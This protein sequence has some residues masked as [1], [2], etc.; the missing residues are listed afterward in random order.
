MSRNS[1]D[2]RDRGRGTSLA[3]LLRLKAIPPLLET[4]E[5][6]TIRVLSSE[7]RQLEERVLRLEETVKEYEE[8]IR[9]MKDSHAVRMKEMEAD[10][11][12]KSG[13][14]EG[15]FQK[16]L[17]AQ[18]TNFHKRIEE[19][20]HEGVSALKS[21][22]DLDAVGYLTAVMVL[23]SG[24]REEQDLEIKTRINLAVALWRFGYMERA[25]QQL[26]EVLTVDPE[27][28]TARRNLERLES[29]RK[30]PRVTKDQA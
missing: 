22:A 1:D 23:L 14:M 29:K 2:I 12:K 20:F 28:A 15:L 27:N 17:D 4:S 21:A 25:M 16:R 19:C 3:D 8:E 5:T 11:Q 13:E 26:S 9:A 10:F 24:K 18:Q 7:K 6:S 30:N